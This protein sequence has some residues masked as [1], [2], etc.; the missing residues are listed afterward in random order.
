MSKFIRLGVLLAVPFALL[1]VLSPPTSPVLAPKT[2]TP[3]TKGSEELHKLVTN[4]SRKLDKTGQDSFTL[5][6]VERAMMD[7]SIKGKEAIALCVLRDNFAA[8]SAG[9]E[10]ITLKALSGYKPGMTRTPLADAIDERFR[11]A[12]EFLANVNRGLYPSGTKSESLAKMQSVQQVGRGNCYFL[13]GVGSRAALDPEAIRKCITDN[14][15]DTSTGVRTFTVIFPREPGVKYVVDDFTDARLLYAEVTVDSGTWA[16]IVTRAYALYMEAH[17][18]NRLVQRVFYKL[19][20]R[21]LPEDRTD[22]GSMNSEGL[23]MVMDSRT[24]R[25]KRVWWAFDDGHIESV[26]K[27]ILDSALPKASPLAK[28][29]ITST[30]LPNVKQVI[31][32]MCEPRDPALVHELLRKS[33]T[34]GKLAATVIK[35]GGAHEASIIGYRPT[36]K[37]ADGKHQSKYG[38]VT[39]RDQA[40]LYDSEQANV[41]S[42]RWWREPGMDSN[43]ICM[44]VEDFTATFSG[45]N[46]VLER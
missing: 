7:H 3:P 20:E 40:G 38:F 15:V 30:L 16:A 25:L 13:S 17:Q 21:I 39:V 32:D 41:L 43:T 19:D 42:G 14:G 46:V 11:T 8:L 10:R 12:E 24:H 36:N 44:T 31:A 1:T 22:R 28:N 9:A 26:F 37:S 18:L 29:L 2:A 35:H 34:D 33:V 45:L 6:D 5:A 23:R 4:I 27:E